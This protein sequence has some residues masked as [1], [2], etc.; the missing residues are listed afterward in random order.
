M[1]RQRHV[2]ATPEWGR[3]KLLAVLVTGAVALLAVVVGLG[4][5]VYYSVL[6]GPADRGTDGAGS[7]DRVEASPEFTQGA[8]S[9]GD[10]AT[11]PS[12]LTTETFEEIVLP[13][14]RVLGPV[15]VSS[16]FPRTPE[17]ALAQLIAIDQRV[18]QSASVDVAQQVITQWAVPGGPT[19]ESWSGVQAVAALLSSA[20]ATRSGDTTLTVSASPEMGLIRDVDEAGAV[21]CVDFVVTATK[22]K[23]ASVAS[24]DCQRMTWVGGRWM[25]GA[26]AEPEQAPSVWPGT[27]AALEAGYRV[28]R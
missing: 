2:E 14:P 5:G 9:S 12:E 17:G 20:G 22:S 19:A 3:G 16:G 11:G 21:V 15:G 28:L 7:Q 8:Q 6:A 27:T 18:L 10:V 23:T 4:L 1:R 26:G 24:A 25:I 13:A